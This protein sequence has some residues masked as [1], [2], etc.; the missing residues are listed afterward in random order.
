MRLLQGF[1]VT[2]LCSALSVSDP[3]VL[4]LSTGRSPDNLFIM[5][6][7]EVLGNEPRSSRPARGDVSGLMVGSAVHRRLKA[8]FAAAAK[9]LEMV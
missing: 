8:E 6:L 9:R 1:A 2:R 4:L 7:C 3:A 5:N